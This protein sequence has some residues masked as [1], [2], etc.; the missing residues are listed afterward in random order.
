MGGDWV[1]LSAKYGFLRPADVVLGP[2]ETTFKR[3]STNPIGPV[4]LREQVEH[5]RLGRYDE[6]IGLGGK[7]YRAAIEAAFEG[8]RV[9]LSFPFA[10]LP[11]G[12]AM[13][14][15]KLAAPQ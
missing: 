4:A 12:K 13:A 14:A 2:Y 15:T 10:G 1:I 8:T 7:E 5:M 9:Q 3:R 11:I 6:V